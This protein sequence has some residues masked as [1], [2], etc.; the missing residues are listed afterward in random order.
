MGASN[1]GF[2]KAI[3]FQTYVQIVPGELEAHGRSSGEG[4]FNAGRFSQEIS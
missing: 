1:D 2:S 3:K 4:T